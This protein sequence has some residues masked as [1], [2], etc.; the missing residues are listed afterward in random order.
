MGEGVF[1][2]VYAWD[3]GNMV[4]RGFMA[5]DLRVDI[6]LLGIT[7]FWEYGFGIFGL[8]FYG[9]DFGNMVSGFFGLIF[10]FWV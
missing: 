10:G 7:G 4:L 2:W 3:F 5:W 6:W 9:W 8:G 1:S